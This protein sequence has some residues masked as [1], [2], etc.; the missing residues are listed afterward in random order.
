MAKNIRCVFVQAI[1]E[2]QE[3]AE[4]CADLGDS[5]YSEDILDI[6]YGYFPHLKKELL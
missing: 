4:G 3:L 6:I 2:I 5:I 1:S